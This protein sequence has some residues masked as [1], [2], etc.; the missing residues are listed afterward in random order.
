MEI[1]SDMKFKRVSSCAELSCESSVDY[2]LPDYL[3]DV[4][5]ILYTECA[6]RP[7]G[8]FIDDGEVEFS[9]IVVYN[10]VYLDSE[11]K[12]CGVSFTSDYDGT[13][14]CPDAELVGVYAQPAVSSYNVRLTGPRRFSAKAVVGGRCDVVTE[15]MI[16]ASGTAFGGEEEPE[17]LTRVMNFR[18]VAMSERVERE[19]AEVLE[20][21]EGA[22]ADELEVVWSGAEVD[23]ESVTAAD[24]SVIVKGEL[25]VY[26]V[27]SA[28]DSPLYFIEREI[29]FEET[30]PFPDVTRGMSLIPEASVVSLVTNINAEE[31]GA[32]IIASVVVEYEV[33]GEYNESVSVVSDAFVKSSA[34]ENTYKD[35]G[36]T[37]LLECVSLSESESCEV[38]CSS[39]PCESLRQVIYLVANPKIEKAVEESGALKLYGEVRFSGVASEVSEEGEISYTGIK[40]TSPIDKTVKCSASF[41]SDLIAEVKL[42]PTLAGAVIDGDKLDINYTLCGNVTLSV[43]KTASVLATSDIIEETKYVETSGRITVYYPEDGET[44]FDVARRFH[45]SKET[46][47][48]DNNISVLTSAD[49]GS[50]DLG[51]YKRIYIF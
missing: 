6:A 35:Y 50:V 30:V 21:L 7:S 29:P 38:D 18:S 10:V 40:F 45:K 36:Y 26:A 37:E 19:Y 25:D 23:F 47:A 46:I 34:T 44:L 12:P 2:T 9:G 48:E 42:T 13:V 20:R 4:R 17:T 49:G 28:P 31:T 39:L 8:K 14:K 11:G 33:R 32:E 1:T 5:K 3:G 15:D 16:A 51:E 43:K 41:A 24:G 22:V 27:V